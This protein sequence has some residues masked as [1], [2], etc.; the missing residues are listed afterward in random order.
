M[1]KEQKRKS[2]AICLDDWEKQIIYGALLGNAFIVDPPKGL[3]CY[4]VIRQSK[5]QDYDSFLY[6]SLE[7]KAFAR[8]AAVYSDTHDYR[9]TSISH[10]DFD[11][12]RNFCY[13]DDKK[14]VTMD[15]LNVLRDVSLMIWYL[16]RGFYKD[17]KFGLNTVNLKGSQ[18]VIH[19]YFNEVGMPCKLEG[20]KV[21]FDEFGK[22]EFLRVIAHRVPVPLRYRLEETKPVKAEVL[23]FELL[24]DGV[25][26]QYEEPIQIISA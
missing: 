11:M 20:C 26:K 8:Q 15:W 9:W 2:R 5:R 10:Q 25:N 3:H 19:Q 4:L 18:S 16:D 22:R 12:V 14:H 6:K 23:S 21:I 13:K 1:N 24:D 17:G 7:L